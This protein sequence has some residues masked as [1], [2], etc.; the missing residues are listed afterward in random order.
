MPKGKRKAQPPEPPSSS[1]DVLQQ[2]HAE[3]LT[4]RVTD[5]KTGYFGVCLANPGYPKPYHARVKRGGKQVSLGSFATAEEAALCVAR[6]PEGEEWSSGK[7]SRRKS[8]TKSMR[9]FH[10]AGSKSFI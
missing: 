8:R 9:S 6:T 2:A 7:R 10:F 4:L 5:N 1:E 3:G